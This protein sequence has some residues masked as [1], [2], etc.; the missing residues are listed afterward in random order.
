M[1][2]L[3]PTVEATWIEDYDAIEGVIQLYIDGSAKGDRSTLERAFH[4]DARMH[5]ALGGHRYDVPIEDL[6][7]V[8]R[9][10]NGHRRALPR[11]DHL[12]GAGRRCR[13][14]GPRGGR[15]LGNRLLYRLLFPCAHQDET[16]RVRLVQI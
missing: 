1:A 8:G 3:A 5:G 6:Q 16:V 12:G 13:R 2:T 7:D 9:N 14:G 4:T 10:A 11:A 15:L